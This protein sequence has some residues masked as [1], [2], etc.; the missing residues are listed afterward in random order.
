MSSQPLF[1]APRAMTKVAGYKL[2]QNPRFWQSE[3]IRYLKSQHPYL[4]LDSAEID[5]RRMDAVKGAAVGSVILGQELAIPIIIKR[6]RPG[7]DPELSPMDVFYHKG[8]Y[9][10][11]DPEAIKNVTHNPRIGEPEKGRDTRAFG[12]NP[13]VGDVT[14]DATPLEYSGQASPFAGPYSG[15][16]MSA[17]ISHELLP[18]WML[19]TASKTTE[20]MKDRAVLFGTTG[21]IG[22]AV[23]GAATGKGVKGR[24]LNALAQS[25][26]GAMTGATAGAGS[27]PVIKALGL[28]KK[29]AK[30][31]ASTI[32]KV[33]KRELAKESGF[34]AGLDAVAENGIVAGL[35]KT[36][37]IDPNDISNFRRMLATNPHIL[38]G[39][40]GNLRLVEIV[41]RRGA[42]AE[43]IKATV[44]NPNIMQ[45]Y[46]RDGR[47]Y[48]KFSGG[49]ESEASTSERKRAL[50]D[51]YPEVVSR[52]KSG[53]VFIDHDGVDQ[54]TWD[55]KQPTNEARPV[56]RAGFYSVR[57]RSGENLVGM[58]VQA[59]MDVDGKTLPMK[60]FV[61]PDGKYA[62]TPELFGV[63]LADRH[64][65]PSQVPAGGQS[66]VFVNYVHGTPI[67]TVPM[68]LMSVRTVRPEG[69][70]KRILY[71]MTEPMTGKRLTLSPVSG[72]QGFERMHVIE[73]G[74]KA[75]ADGPV[76]FMPV[77]SE[78]VALRNPVR[79]AESQDELKKLSS[80]DTGV[81][82]TYTGGQWNIEASFDKEAVAQRGFLRTGFHQLKSLVKTPGRY[83]AAMGKVHQSNVGKHGRLGGALQTAKHYAPG[84]AIAGTG[85]AAAGL[86]AKAVFG[87]PKQANWQNLDEPEAREMLLA[88]GMSGDA[89]VSV[90]RRARERGGIDRGVKIAG[91]HAPQIQGH[92]VIETPRPVY[93]QA[94]IDFVLG[95]RPGPE[96]L[97][98]AAESGHPETL[99]ALLSL[100]FIT[101]Q[102]LRYFTDNV[103]DFEET[104]TRLAALLISIRLGMPHVQEQSVKDALEG[105]SMTVNKLQVLKSAIDHKKERA[106]TSM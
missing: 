102:N 64:R 81:H 60:M 33:V 10:F 93:D 36:A 49:P 17:D 30:E 34:T 14:G 9:K 46:Q 75:M 18:E 96:L 82:V 95:C 97:K 23:R 4:L 56:T 42:N 72:V 47:T 55:V 13:Y 25:A 62:M 12:G 78:W 59:I 35:M 44:K 69:G 79:L 91:L 7:A 50:G 77:D 8:L 16:K 98:S 57:T 39:S 40:G 43:A 37:Y 29:Q 89:A 86:G 3:I 11:L 41:A 104:A 52:L 70:D 38:Q 65:L 45:V 76:Y 88:M 87:G 92:E 27:V 2:P 22:G 71:L 94:T 100:E 61:A 67:A 20:K 63:R 106:P 21:A 5:M 101:P 48:I 31:Q 103:P 26:L 54:V 84:A 51:R 66:G 24:V 80:L 32:K 90:V 85:L 99:D 83:G 53:G 105:L 73:P 1:F 68:R 19:K 28:E 15:T 6:P 58:V 74:V